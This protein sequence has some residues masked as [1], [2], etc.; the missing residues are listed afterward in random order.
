[1]VQRI[2]VLFI[3]DSCVSDGGASNGPTRPSCLV[4]TAACFGGSDS[5]GLGLLF[6]GTD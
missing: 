1:M 3:R 4:H 6:L 2:N 5:P